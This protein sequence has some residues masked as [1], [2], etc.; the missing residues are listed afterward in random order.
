MFMIVLLTYSF[1]KQIIYLKQYYLSLFVVDHKRKH[2]IHIYFY[3]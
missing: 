2:F 1:K 3:C